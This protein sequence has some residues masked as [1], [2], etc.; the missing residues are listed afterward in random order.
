[1]WLK[2]CP[3][4]FKQV[5]YERY[6]D[7]IFVSFEKPEQVLRYVDYMNKR[8]KKMKFSFETEK[9]NSFSFLDVK[10]CRE[11]VKFTTIVFRKDVFSGVYTNFSGFVAL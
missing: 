5:Y 6:V 1:M 2:D 4:A 3:K 10:I 7:V 9:C 11:K 8:H